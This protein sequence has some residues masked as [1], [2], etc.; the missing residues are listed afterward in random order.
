M[1]ASGVLHILFGCDFSE[2]QP[3]VLENLRS[4]KKRKMEGDAG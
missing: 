3:A 1:S 4:E 2:I